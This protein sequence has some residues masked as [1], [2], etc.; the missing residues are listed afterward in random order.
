MYIIME[1]ENEMYVKKEMVIQNYYH[2]IKFLKG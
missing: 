1:D 2:L